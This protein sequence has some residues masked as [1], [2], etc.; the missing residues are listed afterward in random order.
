M[1]IRCV[2]S[3]RAA[4]SAAAPSCA[5]SSTGATS[6]LSRLL[7]TPN[8]VAQA[9]DWRRASGSLLSLVV[10]RDSIEVA[11][12]SHPAF[13]EP[14]VE[15]PD[16]PLDNKTTT[17]H[18][19]AIDTVQRLVSQYNVCGVVVSWPVQRQGW[20]G[21]SC[22][23]VLHTLDNISLASGNGNMD[24]PVCLYDSTH[25]EAPAMDEWGRCALYSTVS[26]KSVHVASKE[27]YEAT[28]TPASAAVHSSNGTALAA[29]LCHD[30]MRDHW[31]N[32]N[33]AVTATKGNAAAADEH[34]LED[35]PIPLSARSASL[36]NHQRYHH[37][38]SDAPSAPSSRSNAS[39][40]WQEQ[41]ERASAMA[42]F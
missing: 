22:G 19:I 14:A 34:E 27:Q 20:V 7:T 13:M 11:V 41:G 18:D 35:W 30:F 10:H 12:A 33:V 40:T 31:P 2:A 3:R 28:V 25:T 26:T 21:A 23:R 17:K 36:L 24:R 9:L 39:P 8:K 29:Q 38:V 15:L 6:S 42:Y 4:A 32:L 1:A 16:I 37:L 5:P